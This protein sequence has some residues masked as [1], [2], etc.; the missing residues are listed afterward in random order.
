MA[1]VG[2]LR[3]MEEAGIYPD[4]IVGCSMGAVVGAAYASGMAIDD[5]EKAI[6]KLRVRNLVWPAFGRGGLLSAKRIERILQRYMG[7]PYFSDLKI[8]FR[9]VALDLLSQ[10]VIT[11]SEGRV[12]E[13]VSAS[14]CIPVLFR[15]IKRKNALLVDGGVITRVPYR[16]VKEMGADVVVAVDVL[17]YRPSRK[18]NPSTIDVL[19]NIMDISDN[20]RTQANRERDEGV[21]DVWVQPNLDEISQYEFEKFALAN[22]YGYEAGKAKIKEIKRALR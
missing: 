6:S 14:S 20:I 18:T 16:Q 5:I 9:C 13:C 3:A 22:Q 7:N 17:G 11:L 4:Y 15:P 10:Q 2:F 1:H 12:N 21:Y 19:L 8:P